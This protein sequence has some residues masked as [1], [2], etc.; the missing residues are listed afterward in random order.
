MDLRERD[1][2]GTGQMLC[3]SVGDGAADVGELV[4]AGWNGAEDVVRNNEVH[5][6]RDDQTI[7][8]TSSTAEAA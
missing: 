4:H 1:G 7:S 8:T 2:P 5:A 6:L 3:S